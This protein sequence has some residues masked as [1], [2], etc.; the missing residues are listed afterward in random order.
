M[1]G[2]AV[3]PKFDGW[4]VSVEVNDEVPALDAQRPRHHRPRSVGSTA[5]RATRRPGRRLV[6]GAG[7]LADFYRLLGEMGRRS[8]APAVVVFD[9]LS[10]DGDIVTKLPYTTRRALLEKLYLPG[11]VL[12]P[13]FSGTD[14]DVLL[15]SCEE[16][17]MEGVVLRRLSSIYR[18]G[19]RS[20]DWRKVKCPA[21]LD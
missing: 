18:P 12:A 11:A 4:R 13:S 20:S 7:T 8:G 2:W 14:V 9:V 5:G 17:G 21:W 6:S 3:E 19:Q 16:F 15:A 1:S 10:I